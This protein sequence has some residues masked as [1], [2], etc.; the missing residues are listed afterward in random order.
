MKK[1]FFAIVAIAA[2]S[3]GLTSCGLFKS[4]KPAETEVSD[5]I[6]AI[7]AAHNSRNS[8]NWEGVYTGVTP[9][10]DCEGISVQL[11]LNTDETYQLSY[12]YLGN[13]DATPY[14]VSGKFTWDEDGGTIKLDC[15]D[16]PPYYMVGENRLFQL[17]MEGNP[18][19]SDHADM[20]VLTKKAE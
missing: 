6:D 12:T 7:D 4:S 20:Y 11:T 8:L 3:Q 2:M 1:T 10:A 5:A 16:A 19:D 13:Q 14:V 9:C 17:D 15:K 18:I